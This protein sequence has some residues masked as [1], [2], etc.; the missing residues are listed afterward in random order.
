MTTKKKYAIWAT[1]LCPLTASASDL[2]YTFLDFQRPEV[3][4]DAFGVQTPVPGQTVQINALDGEGIAVAGSLAL[5]HGLYFS[6]SYRSSI[7]D[8]TGSISSPLVS[9]NVTD[10]FD[11]TAATLALGYAHEFGDNFDLI[12]EISY[13]SSTY[14]FG[15]FAGENF[16][17]DDSGAG[18]RLGVRWNPARPIELYLFAK[19]S[20]VAKALLSEGT[21][22]KGNSTSVGVRWY[23]FENLGVGVEYDSGDVDTTTISMRFS[24]GN[25]PW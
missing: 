6:G 2:S 23:F 3:T 21:F 18:A 14:D 5:V 10:T 22:E 4:V 19:Y 11:L 16:D 24:F 20:P 15:S 8:V 12:A 7:V 17:I 25:L 1:F 13:D 9:V